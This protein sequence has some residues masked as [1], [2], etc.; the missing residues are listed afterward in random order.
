MNITENTLFIHVPSGDTNIY[1]R[2]IRQR[3]KAVSLPLKPTAEQLSKFGYEPVVQTSRPTGVV[4]E[5]AE[6]VLEDG[7]YKQVWITRE[8]TAEELETQ[9]SDAKRNK[10]E[11]VKQ[12]QIE[13]LSQGVPYE[14]PG[15]VK[16]IQV[17][18]G[19]RTNLASLYLEASRAL[20]AGDAEYVEYFRV[21]EDTT[22]VLDA[23]GVMAMVD[24]AS[25]SYKALLGKFWLFKDAIKAATTI[26][27]VNNLVFE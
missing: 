11:E 4:V 8:Y 16:H 6:V 17:R 9:L 3:E 21:F 22:E 27:E 14:F 2:Q 1:L 7:V 20:E 26:S 25:S 24:S 12:L 15:G 19:D 5:K 18:D 23:A 13:K 10:L